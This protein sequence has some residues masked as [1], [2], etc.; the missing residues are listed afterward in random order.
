MLGP[1]AMEVYEAMPDNEKDGRGSE[2]PLPRP[3]NEGSCT[4]GAKMRSP[5]S[6]KLQQNVGVLVE[7]PVDEHEEGEP[8]GII[9]RDRP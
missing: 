2:V 5:A 9:I 8:L 7:T 6:L 3:D 4:A 1:A